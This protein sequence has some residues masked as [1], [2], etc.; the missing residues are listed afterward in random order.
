MKLLIYAFI[1][2]FV[3]VSLAL[4]AQ[5][6]PGYVLI[7]RGQTTVETSLSLFL[8][9]LVGG[10]VLMYFA[11]R[12][13]VR[14]WGLP[15]R[16]QRWRQVRRWRR[17][18]QLTNQGLIELA[19][20]DWAEAEKRLSRSAPNSEMP[21][22]NYLSAARAAQKLSA[23]ERRD[24]YLSLAHRSMAGTDTAVALTQAEL[25]LTHGQLEQALATLMH[26][27]ASVPAHPYVLYLLMRLYERLKSWGDLVDLLP[28]LRKHQAVDGATLDQLTR[29]VHRE[30][31][32]LAARSGNAARLDEVWETLSR[33]L[34][35]DPLLV[36]DYARDL[37]R[38]GQPARAEAVLRETLK[39]QWCEP[40]VYLYGLSES[41]DTGKQ[42]SQAEQWLKEHGRSAELLLTLGRLC[43]RHKLWGKARTY[44]EASLGVEPRPE[45]YRELGTLLDRLGEEAAAVEYCRK[46]LALAVQECLCDALLPVH[47]EG[48]VDPESSAQGTQSL[49]YS[50]ASEK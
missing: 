40:L 28:A 42:L 48:L 49:A 44:F 2:L 14:A 4:L 25:Q 6:D 11:L 12:I 10:F 27:R 9:L 39:R 33:E 3:A 13:V 46:G 43:V 7:A 36:E 20:G 19:E 45:T 5:Q 16:L 37:L 26:L 18:R 22:I 15:R 1:V 50:K 21:L 32:T 47:D 41:A 24:H 38:V 34:R 23:P 31:L 29:T 35:R 8:I 17:A 30:T